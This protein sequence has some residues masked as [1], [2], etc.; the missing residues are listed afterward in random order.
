VIPTTTR[1]ILVVSHTDSAFALERDYD[2]S[3]AVP[4]GDKIVS[5]PP[6]F[7]C[8]LWFGRVVYTYTR[9]RG[10]TGSTAGT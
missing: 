5:A 10:R 7:S 4:A 2:L 6:D 1:H 9:D 3:A 8:R